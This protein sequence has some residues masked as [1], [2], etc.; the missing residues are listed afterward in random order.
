MPVSCDRLLK[1]QLCERIDKYI[2]MMSEIHTAQ[3]H[4]YISTA[5]L[6]IQ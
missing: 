1:S 5:L 3:Y 2:D 4:A 6:L